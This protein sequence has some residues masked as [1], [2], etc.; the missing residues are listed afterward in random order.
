MKSLK[1]KPHDLDDRAAVLQVCLVLSSESDKVTGKALREDL[2]Q[3]LRCVEPNDCTLITSYWLVT[4]AS[5][6][7]ALMGCD[8]SSS[9]SFVKNNQIRRLCIWWQHCCRPFREFRIQCYVNI[10]RP[11]RSVSNARFDFVKLLVEKL[12]DWCLCVSMLGRCAVRVY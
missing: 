4:G 11:R 8:A 3:K 1:Q 7:T 2:L 12:G 5:T 9:A 6:G 10:T